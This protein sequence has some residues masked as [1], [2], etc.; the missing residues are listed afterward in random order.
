M[1]R[2][3]LLWFAWQICLAFTTTVWSQVA[4]EKNP[5]LEL[6]IARQNN[7]TYSSRL[8]LLQRFEKGKY[9]AELSVYHENLLNSTRKQDPFVQLY[10]RTSLWQY[11]RIHKQWELTSW[12]ETDQFF[13][14]GNQ[15][16]SIYAGATY[17]PL[18]DVSISPIAGYSWDYRSSVLDQGFT[19]GL[20]VRSRHDFGDG[21]SMRTDVFARV[22]YINP[23]HQRNLILS[24]EWAKTFSE[25]AG[26]SFELEGGSNEMDNYQSGSIERIK[27]DT[28]SA[29][30]G[31]QYQLFKGMFWESDNQV[32]ITRR[33]FDYDLFTIKSPEFNDLLF[34][35]INWRTR[36]KFSYSGAKMDGYFTYEFESL[37]RRYE[38]EN[39]MELPG[40][41]FNR[42]L[43]REQQKDYF[44]NLTRLEMRVNYRFNPRQK[45]SL[46]GTNRYLQY[47]TPSETNYD[48][49]DELNYALSG[50]W[51]A[52]W[53][54]NFSTRY[55]LI[56]NVRRYA[57]LFKERS[58]D[59]YTQPSLRMEFAYK[60]QI[61]PS[62][63][64]RGDQFIYVTYNVKDFEDRNLT[65]RST[66]N[67]ESRLIARYRANRKLTSEF[68]AYRK[69][70]HVSYLN[71]EQFTETTLDT[72][73]T[74]ILEQTNRYELKS[75][76][77]N[78]RLYFDFGYKHFSQLRYLN[79]SMTS[80]QNI[81]TPINL[82]IRNHQ[83]GI[84]TGV[85]YLHRKPAN[86][87]FSVWWQVQYLDYKYN[88]IAKLITLSTNYQ[89]AVLRKAIVNFRPFF[90]CQL[91]IVLGGNQR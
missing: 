57:F 72:T 87:E 73:T 6:T 23:R 74:Y 66:R 62:L 71:W 49:H 21:L 9:R 14:T 45:F 15:R 75:P 69:E 56:G 41:E 43:Q 76:W 60:W 31:L 77:E 34:N 68:S 59:N 51:N 22:K 1:S 19:P 10:L 13:N 17:T 32:I 80:L 42:L 83:T 89:E 40:I 36:Q 54:R 86:A 85:R 35:Q 2:L 79:T 47:D 52:S 29:R 61:S 48:D 70:I 84:V 18:P 33:K 64:I 88:E 8:D 91:N 65:D 38:L 63:S 12:L 53:S 24:S 25:Q 16:L 27:A 55:K 39:S 90:R 50:E 58:Q 26:I 5:G 67:L 3:L 37:G 11:Y 30:I 4:Q 20:L 82:H 78:A 7:F 28:L 81:L 46:I 44:R